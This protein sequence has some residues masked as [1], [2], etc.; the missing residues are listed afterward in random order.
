MVVWGGHP[1]RR[2]VHVNS[3][4]ANKQL[5][6]MLRAPPRRER[7]VIVDPPPPLPVVVVRAV[8]MPPVFVVRRVR[9]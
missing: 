6:E 8:P 9:L 3:S 2:V 1:F 7:V 5:V 4:E